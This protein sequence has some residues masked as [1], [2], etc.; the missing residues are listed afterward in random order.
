MQIKKEIEDHDIVI[1]AEQN[2]KKR[3]HRKSRK[4]YNARGYD[5]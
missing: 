4:P 3:H 2:I 1:P 5:S